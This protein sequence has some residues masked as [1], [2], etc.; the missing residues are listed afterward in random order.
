LLDISE[1]KEDAPGFHAA[2]SENSGG[3]NP[4]AEPDSDD[5]CDRLVLL[6]GILAFL[7]RGSRSFVDAED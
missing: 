3:Q 6:A 7:M 1:Q 2:A 4:A 5:S